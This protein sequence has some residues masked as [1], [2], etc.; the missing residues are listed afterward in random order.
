MSIIIILQFSCS[1]TFLV[2]VF[3]LPIKHV[4]AYRSHQEPGL[5][6][7]ATEQ[8]RK[9][10]LTVSLPPSRDSER[11]RRQR[12][13]RDTETLGTSKGERTLP[14]DIWLEQLESRSRI[15]ILTQLRQQCRNDYFR[16]E[17][18]GLAGATKVSYGIHNPLQS[19]EYC[20]F[21]QNWAHFSSLAGATRPF[22]AGD[23]LLPNWEFKSRCTAATSSYTT[24]QKRNYILDW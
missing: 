1:G 20:R 24:K 22:R 14:L 21:G 23:L 9:S 17:K 18:F 2:E 6:P 3:L 19:W 15:N 13:E 8:S 12:G 11:S 5:D 4:T 10:R 16:A 7:R